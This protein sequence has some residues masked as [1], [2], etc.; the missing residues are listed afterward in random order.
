MTFDRHP[1]L[2]FANISQ[3][4]LGLGYTGIGDMWTL[5]LI[6]SWRVYKYALRMR[7]IR[8]S[9]TTRR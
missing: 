5:Y 2:I 8:A 9:R 7:L 6:D 3:S 1:V 4:C